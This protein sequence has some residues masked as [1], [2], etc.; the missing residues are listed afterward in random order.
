MVLFLEACLE[1]ELK[2][3]SWSENRS[4]DSHKPVSY[5]ISCDAISTLVIL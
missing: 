2:L 5:V 4:S 3:N 1:I